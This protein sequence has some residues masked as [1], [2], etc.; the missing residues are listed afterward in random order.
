R[1]RD[2]A[3][4]EGWARAIAQGY[5]RLELETLER[6][7]NG[8]M[9][10]IVHK[11]GSSEVRTEYDPRTALT[12]LRLHRDNAGE[13]ERREAMIAELGDE[14]ADELRDRLIAKL[15]RVRVQLLGAER[16]EAGGWAAIGPPALEL[17]GP[18]DGD[19]PGVQAGEAE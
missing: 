7:I 9:R 5:A 15:K 14:G 8:E 18:A 12:L 3:F 19:A 4:R 16:A 6:A 10:T 17:D 11:D 13:P 1:A 2:A